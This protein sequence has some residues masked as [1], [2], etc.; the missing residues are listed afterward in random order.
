MIS[1]LSLAPDKV[2]AMTVR[3]IPGDSHGSYQPRHESNQRDHDA[4]VMLP[5]SPPVGY[6]AGDVTAVL[7]LV[8]PQ[9][10]GEA[11]SGETL[12]GEAVADQQSVVRNSA[13][14]AAGSLVSRVTGLLRTI[15]ISAA[16]GASF[17]GNDYN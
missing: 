2:S 9:R 3:G 11:V 10:L 6:D 5:I 1:A 12:G 7:P 15:A 17:I 4:T 14:M 8:V 13:V 16:L